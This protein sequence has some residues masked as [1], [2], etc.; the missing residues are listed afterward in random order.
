MLLRKNCEM[1]IWNRNDW[2]CKWQGYKWF[3]KNWKIISYGQNTVIYAYYTA[4]PRHRSAW[5]TENLTNPWK[6]AKW[7]SSINV[8]QVSAQKFSECWKTSAITGM[9]FDVDG[10]SIRRNMDWVGKNL[11]GYIGLGCIILTMESQWL[12]K[13]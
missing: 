1:P 5:C 9:F 6:I 2:K 11:Y 12:M 13:C 10:I 3:W 4:F 7:Y 8:N